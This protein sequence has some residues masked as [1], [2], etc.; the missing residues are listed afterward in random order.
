MEENKIK[1]ACM[2]QRLSTLEEGIKTSHKKSIPKTNALLPD[3]LD[4]S[5]YISS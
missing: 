4:H 3:K 1:N 2:L 5:L